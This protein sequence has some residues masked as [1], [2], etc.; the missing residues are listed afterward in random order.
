MRCSSGELLNEGGRIVCVSSISGI[1]GN[2][3]QTNYATSKAGVIG[4]VDA[5]APVVAKRGRDDQRGRAGLHRDAD[6]GEDAV[7]L[8]EAG[9]GCRRCRRAACRWT[10]PRRSPGSRRPPR[11][12]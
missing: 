2:A 8:R 1:A 12:A 9:G 6:D 11:R 5:L 7:G 4:I 3:G 10:W